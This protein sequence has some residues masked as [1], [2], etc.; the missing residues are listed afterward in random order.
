MS[1]ATLLDKEQEGNNMEKNITINIL[2]QDPISW[3]CVS[4]AVIIVAIC[5]WGSSEAEKTRRL[6]MLINSG[7]TNAIIEFIKTD[8]IEVLGE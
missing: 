8:K 1:G 5:I 4:A 6:D 7:N 3:L 2:P